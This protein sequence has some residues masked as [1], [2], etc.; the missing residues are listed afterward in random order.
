M[1]EKETKPNTMDEYLETW[2]Q[3]RDELKSL[4]NQG[5]VNP[6]TR[7]AIKSLVLVVKADFAGDLTE[8]RRDYEKRRITALKM[9]AAAIK[10]LENALAEFDDACN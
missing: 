10:G 4:K 6:E 1:P 3:V 7:A 5:V 2:P 8:A 9:I